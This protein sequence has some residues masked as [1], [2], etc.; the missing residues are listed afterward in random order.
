MVRGESIRDCRKGGR[1]WV[2]VQVA[3]KYREG[4]V[5]Q[6]RVD[7]FI[8]KRGGGGDIYVYDVKGGRRGGG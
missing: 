2:G 7:V 3:C 5:A 8:G 4:K 6:E 1:V